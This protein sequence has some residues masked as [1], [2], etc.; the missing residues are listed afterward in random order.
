MWSSEYCIDVMIL[1]LI[2]NALME[3]ATSNMV[4]YFLV[5]YIMFFYISTFILLP[6]LLCLLLIR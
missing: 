2:N 4:T 3:L 1:E 5:S 6:N